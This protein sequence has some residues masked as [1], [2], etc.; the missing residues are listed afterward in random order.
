MGRGVRIRGGE[1]LPGTVVPVS[2]ILVAVVLVP[3]HVGGRAAADDFCRRRRKGASPQDP[4]ATATFA[5]GLRKGRLRGGLAEA[6]RAW[7]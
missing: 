2:R 5:G 4:A 6:H 1:E 7:D 3:V